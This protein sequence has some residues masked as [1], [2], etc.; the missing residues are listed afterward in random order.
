MGIAESIGQKVVTNEPQNR[1]VTV[2]ASMT[3][4][5]FATNLQTTS[6]VVREN[7][8]IISSK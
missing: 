2:G 7:G 3:I 4:T 8:K 6:V 5:A 1:T